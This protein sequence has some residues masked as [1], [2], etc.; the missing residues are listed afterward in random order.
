MRNLSLRSWWTLLLLLLVSGMFAVVGGLVLLYRLPQVEQRNRDLLEERVQG[1]VYQLEQYTR[2]VEDQLRSF[3]AAAAQLDVRGQQ[4][5]AQAV[6]RHSHLY[7]AIYVLDGEQ[8]V[9]V[10]ALPDDQSR[11]LLDQ[12]R[13]TDL[14]A[15][16]LVR[17]LQAPAS[18]A[19][20]ALVWSDE[21]LSVLSGRNT[22]ALG[23]AWQGRSYILELSA[24]QLLASISRR[25]AAS[26]VDFE[27]L[28]IDQRGRQLA[29]LNGTAERQLLRD[30]SG[31][32]S[33][34]AALSGQPLPR[35]ELAADGQER[36]Y[37]GK[38]SDKLG[39]VL[40]ASSPRGM[41]EYHYRVTVLLVI[42]GLIAGPLLALIAAPLAAAVM[43]RPLTRLQRQVRAIAAGERELP[44]T[45]RSGIT[46][47]QRLSEDIGLMVAQLHSREAD[48]LRAAE[49]LSATLESTPSIAIQ[50][51]D[52][53]ARVLYWNEASTRMYGYSAADAVGFSIHERQLYL[54]DEAQVRTLASV[55]EGVV[56]TG[57][58][59]GPAE[60]PLRHKDGRDLV[61]LASLFAIPAEDGSRLVV[62]MD[63]DVSERRQA[64]D[65]LAASEQRQ[66]LIFSASPIALSVGDAKDSFRITAVNAAWER[67][68]KRS[69]DE[70]RGRNGR[71]FG[72]WADEADRQRFLDQLSESGR[73]V[74]MEAELLDGRGRKVL[75]RVSARLASIGSERLLL[76]ALEDI[77]EQRRAEE[78]IRQLN[79]QLEQRVADRTAELSLA[80]A[81]LARNL[82]TLTCTQQQLVQAEK[83]AALG[84]LVAGIAHELNTPIGNGLMAIS[85]MSDH[86]EQLKAGLRSGL[87]RSMLEDYVAAFDQGHQIAL[88]NLTRAAEL[89]TG[90]KQVA[91]D[92]STA[93]RRQFDLAALVD[94]IMLTLRPSLK[95]TPYLIS[96]SCPPGIKLDSYPGP[97]GQVLTNLIN[98]AVIHGFDER[99]H[100][101]VEIRCETLPGDQLRLIVSDDGHGIPEKALARV[102]D[103]FFTTRMGRG[104]TGLG[105]HIS[106]SLVTHVLGG[107]IRVESR[108]G[109]GTQVI[110]ELPRVAPGP[111]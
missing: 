90:F 29:S 67:L 44:A 33:F 84:K 38:R 54:K 108:V 69:A 95:R 49:R 14:S 73:D 77:G 61:I 42:A 88:R 99:T 39:W 30:F 10:L 98:N 106:H 27:L 32:T 22:V 28:V 111:G 7:N 78:E 5:L 12:L 19:S 82:E 81:E 65:A 3:A 91:V 43:A 17:A 8:R 59:F 70:V 4:Q 55:I 51:F 92:Q 72:L 71:E 60:F 52:R 62:C 6:A 93:Q 18:G 13:G 87:K 110:I 35:Q 48:V 57:K 2:M 25:A 101:S 104:G 9:A 97:L 100:G 76:M 80:N 85:T 20:P 96:S 41:A 109:E 105:L 74:A 107:S 50:W 21:Y 46:E 63:V 47:L 40:M 34:Q 45:K 15:N 58:P 86:A 94:E 79:T 103:P 66:E 37:A 31:S 89:I 23:M 24:Q 1:A 56:D 36:A 83:L 75:C 64:L 16:P 53:D 102:F 26:P 68:L 11:P